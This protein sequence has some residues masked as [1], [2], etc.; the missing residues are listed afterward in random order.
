M[1]LVLN[2]LLHIAC[3]IE[4]GF[5][6]SPIKHLLLFLVV[7]I[8]HTSEERSLLGCRVALTLNLKCTRQSNVDVL[9]NN[10]T[11]VGYACTVVL[12]KITLV[13]ITYCCVCTT[14]ECITT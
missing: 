13:I 14:I 11:L 7:G 4:D 2:G 10:T 6:Q 1:Q 12:T 9:I 3:L 5:I 8:E